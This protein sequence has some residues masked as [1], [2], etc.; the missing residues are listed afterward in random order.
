MEKNILSALLLFSAAVPILYGGE[1]FQQLKNLE[2]PA[3]KQVFTDTF[4]LEK[5]KKYEISGRAVCEKNVGRI[6]LDVRF[7]DINRRLIHPHFVNAL[8]GS[9]TRLLKKAG[10][11]EK[12][13]LI[14]DNPLW[15]N[16]PKYRIAVFDA[17]KDLSDLP[18]RFLRILR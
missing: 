1:F 17:R 18:N 5:S 11:G 15:K 10:K 4:K 3:G 13:F 2:I 6:S 7:Y 8:N 16:Y 12:S 14:A 9:E